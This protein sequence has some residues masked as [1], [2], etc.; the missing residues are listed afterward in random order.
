MSKL[1]FLMNAYQFGI[2][3]KKKYISN[4]KALKNEIPV[5]WWYGTHE[6]TINKINS[7]LVEIQ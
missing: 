5:D 1:E 2:I 4:L 7:I 3:D 6:K